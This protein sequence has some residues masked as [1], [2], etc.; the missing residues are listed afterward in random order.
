ML[1]RVLQG[2][3]VVGAAASLPAQIPV[4]VGVQ[5]DGTSARIRGY[6]PTLATG[7]LLGG[8]GS[9]GLGP[10]RL[11][12]FY[13]EGRLHDG[14][15]QPLFV[16]GG[17][18]TDVQLLPWLD[19]G[20]GPVARAYTLDSTTARRIWLAGRVGVAIP[21]IGTS[22]R[23]DLRLWR[24]FVTWAGGADLSHVAGGEV[25]IAYWAPAHWWIRLATTFD[26]ATFASQHHERLTGLILGAGIGR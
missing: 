19:A 22:V 6:S 15:T 24:S 14:T 3:L 9:A 12:V 7:T 16:E 17:V 2:L 10:L 1:T 20:L 25:G 11:S 21:L 8:R 23:T 4:Q 13:R 5:F 18:A 26:D